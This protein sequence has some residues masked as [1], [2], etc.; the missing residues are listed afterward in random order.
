MAPLTAAIDVSEISSVY[1][2][3]ATSDTERT[4]TVTK[5]VVG[6]VSEGETYVYGDANNDTAVTAADSAMIMQ[7]V[8]TDTPTTL[9]TVTDKYM[10]YIDV[11]NS[12][13]LTAA[14]A[15]YVL[16]KSLDS[17]FKMPCEK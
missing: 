10:T 16:Q 4:L 5:P 8:L 2:V 11:D 7:K 14:D 17:T 9:E 3:T 1:F 6:V 12:G 13:V 15:T